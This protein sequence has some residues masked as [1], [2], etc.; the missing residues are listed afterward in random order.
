MSRLYE[1]VFDS[2]VWRLRF[3][4]L[5]ELHSRGQLAQLWWSQCPWAIGWFFA[6]SADALLINSKNCL[7]AEWVARDYDV[8]V[9]LADLEQVELVSCS[10]EGGPVRLVMPIEPYLVFNWALGPGNYNIDVGMGGD[11]YGYGLPHEHYPPR[12]TRLA[13]FFRRQGVCPAIQDMYDYPWV[14]EKNMYLRVGE[15]VFDRRFTVRQERVLPSDVTELLPLLMA[16]S[17]HRYFLPLFEPWRK[18]AEFQHEYQRLRGQR[19]MVMF[20]RESFFGLASS[21]DNRA[22]SELEKRGFLVAGSHFLHRH[23]FDIYEQ[24]RAVAMSHFE[25][26]IPELASCKYVVLVSRKPSAGQLLAEAA[27]LGVLAISSPQK[28]FTRLLFPPELHATTVDEAL[29]KIDTLEAQPL[30]TAMLRAMVRVRAERILGAGAAPP[31]RQYLQVLA[32]LRPPRGKPALP[33]RR[34]CSPPNASKPE[35]APRFLSWETPFWLFAAGRTCGSNGSV[36]ASP[37]TPAASPRAC[38][39]TCRLVG[40]KV[41]AFDESTRGCSAFH[42]CKVQLPARW[43]T[44]VY[45]LDEPL[46]S[47]PVISLV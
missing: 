35:Q 7:Y 23:Y 6:W 40:G 19:G 17:I 47:E 43:N 21:E 13:G 25:N 8:L 5:E 42:H 12:S 22:V 45:V 2:A 18:A 15:D 36:A 34:L 16:P 44:D 27:L 14:I 1:E 46:G 26:H 9:F 20:G 29:A 33:L 28:Y 4:S 38:A 30:H 41:F 11:N 32:G 37:A 31:L 10:R 3:K 24:P 39:F